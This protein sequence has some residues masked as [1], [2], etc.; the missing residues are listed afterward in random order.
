MR[1]S[2]VEDRRAFRSFLRGLLIVPVMHCLYGSLLLLSS[3]LLPVLASNGVLPTIAIISMFG[4]GAVQAIYLLPLG[5]YLKR[6]GK[7]QVVN[8]ISSGAAITALLNGACFATV[9][10]LDKLPMLNHSYGTPLILAFW[11]LGAVLSLIVL[12]LLLIN[13]K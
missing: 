6:K 5:N 10:F 13:L 1:R 8:G 4:L 7:H 12:M 9:P 3:V 11:G 2:T